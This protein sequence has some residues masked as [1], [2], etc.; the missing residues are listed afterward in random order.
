MHTFLAV[1]QFCA[2]VRSPETLVDIYLAQARVTEAFSKEYATAVSAY[3]PFAN[4]I[5]VL[6]EFS[7]TQSGDDAFFLSDELDARADAMDSEAARLDRGASRLRRIAAEVPSRYS[8]LRR[9]R[10]RAMRA[11]CLA[12]LSESE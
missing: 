2:F 10:V 12:V 11:E 1:A 7:M 5:A 9:F 8:G 6:E 4:G 3:E